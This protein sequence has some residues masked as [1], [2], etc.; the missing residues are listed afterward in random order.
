MTE[1]EAWQL[2]ADA[3]EVYERDFVPAIFGEW[4]ARVCDAAQVSSADSVL[5]VACGTGVIAREALRRGATA[6]GVDINPGM[7]A[8]AGRVAPNAAFELGDAAALPFPANAFTKTLCQFAFMYLPD[9][10]TAI[11]EMARVTAPGG[12]LAIAVWTSLED[13]P[14]YQLLADIAE[15]AHQP[16]VA[17]TM[18]APF[19]LGEASLVRDLFG[20]AGVH[21]AGLRHTSGSVR[22]DS[23]DAL[24]HAEIAGTPL[25]GT[26]GRDGYQALLNEARVALAPFCTAGG[27]R[28]PIGAHIAIS[29][30]H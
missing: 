29:R 23:I 2:N 22:F 8:V 14:G 11:Q 5:D 17:A 1:T 19:V 28:F 16:A 27:V 9:R 10:V 12:T 7:L 18:R 6:T 30:K 26:L 15:R 20:R 25:A 24:V 21:L 4:A 13:A 3:A